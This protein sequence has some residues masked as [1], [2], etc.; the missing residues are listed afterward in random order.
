MSETKET[1]IRRL[2]IT[3]EHYYERLTKGSSD[4]IFDIKCADEIAKIYS[5]YEIVEKMPVWPFD[6]RSIARL[7]IM[8]I[9]PLIAFLITEVLSTGSV[10]H[11]FLNKLLSGG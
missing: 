10:L 2:A 7:F 1:A 8:Y 5:L 6:V 11:Q 4:T 9:F 3:F